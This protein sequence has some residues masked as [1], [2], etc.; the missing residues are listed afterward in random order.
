LRSCIP[1]AKQWRPSLKLRVQRPPT[2][3]TF[4]AKMSP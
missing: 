4:R 1:T 2:L 3:R